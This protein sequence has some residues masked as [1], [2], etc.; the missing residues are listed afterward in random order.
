M[1]PAHDRRRLWDHLR[2][3]F[4]R[5]PKNSQAMRGP[6]QRD[7]RAFMELAVDL[8]RH[9][10]SEPGRKSPKVG[11]VVVREGVLLGDA[12]RGELAPRDHAEFTLLEWEQDARR[13]RDSDD[14]E[15]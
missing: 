14:P 11:A 15:N 4:G 7:D 1:D 13:R 9:C 8:A 12:F 6:V 10:V 3:A 5:D 2:Y